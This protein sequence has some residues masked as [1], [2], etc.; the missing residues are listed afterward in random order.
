MNVLNL[1]KELEIFTGVF[2]L[3]EGE[4]DSANGFGRIWIR[5]IGNQLPQEFVLKLG[6]EGGWQ[7]FP[8]PKTGS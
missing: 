6:S 8:M 3:I 7:M 5:P 4:T 2:E 1:P